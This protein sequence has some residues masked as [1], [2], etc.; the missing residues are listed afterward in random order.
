[1]DGMR[2]GNSD[3]FRHL[4][5]FKVWTSNYGLCSICWWCFFHSGWWIHRTSR[6][7]KPASSEFLMSNLFH[8]SLVGTLSSHRFVVIWSVS[9]SLKWN[10]STSFFLWLLF[11]FSY[12]SP[13]CLDCIYPSLCIF[14]IK[15][16]L[17]DPMARVVAET[18]RDHS[19]EK[20]TGT[21]RERKDMMF[22][23][24]RSLWNKVNIMGRNSS[25]RNRGTRR[26]C[27][28]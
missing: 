22:Q 1:M 6:A 24:A 23:V 15:E 12:C 5:D 16:N 25:N 27:E 17:P 18:E 14:K 10:I 4:L 11:T 28:I 2:M 26:L 9:R 3:A 19:S 7:E 8:E 13:I 20:E 21:E